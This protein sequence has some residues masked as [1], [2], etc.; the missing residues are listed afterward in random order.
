LS[1]DSRLVVLADDDP[2]VRDLLTS[3]VG[4]ELGVLVA[5]AEDGDEVLRVAARDRPALVLVDVMMPRVGGFEVA[6][7]LKADPE[8]RDIPVV[9]IS[10][11]ASRAA[12]L[13]AGCDDFVAKPFDLDSFVE[14]L[15]RW[16]K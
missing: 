1:V 13:A 2:E 15:R 4:L 7:R 9:A 12:A 11:G 6:R 10:A 8:T 5:E 16:L 14:K 3:I